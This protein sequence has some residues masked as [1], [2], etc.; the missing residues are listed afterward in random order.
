MHILCYHNNDYYPVR[1]CAAG[2]SV[3]LCLYVCIL[4][5]DQ[6]T[7][8]KFGL[9]V[10]LWIYMHAAQLVRYSWWVADQTLFLG[11]LFICTHTVSPRG[12]MGSIYAHSFGQ[13]ILIRFSEQRT[14]LCVPWTLVYHSS[15]HMCYWILQHSLPSI[16]AWHV[17]TNCVYFSSPEAFLQVE[18]LAMWN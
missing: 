9:L 2:S 12:F 18:G 8:P 16:V 13:P 4:I 14:G 11:I 5:C 17:R 3:W 10:C 6:K 1:A 15:P 7:S